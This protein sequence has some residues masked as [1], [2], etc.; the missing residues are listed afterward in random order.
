MMA[1]LRGSQGLGQM[2]VREPDGRVGVRWAARGGVR[3]EWGPDW[4]AWV[5]NVKAVPSHHTIYA[6]DNRTWK[7]PNQ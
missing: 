7:T 3:Q 1:I 4:G 5:Y 6:G 2:G